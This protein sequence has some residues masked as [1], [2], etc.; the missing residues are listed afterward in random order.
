MPLQHQ[1]QLF[2]VLKNQIQETFQKRHPEIDASIKNWKGKEIK[3]FQKDLSDKVGG[4]ISEK[5]FYT[6]IKV[7]Q[8]HKLPR[9][10][11]L[12]MLA[13]YIGCVSWEDFEAQN[14]N[15]LTPVAATAN[16]KPFRFFKKKY[17]WVVGVGLVLTSVLM[18]SLVGVMPRENC[19][20]QFCFIDADTKE[21]LAG[22]D[23]EILLLEENESPY[24]L[25]CDSM[26]CFQVDCE[27]KSVVK[28][29]IKAPYYQI[30]T[31]SRSLNI[32]DKQEIISIEVDDYALMLHYF[33][34]TKI[35]DWQRRRQQLQEIIAANAQIIQVYS[36]VQIGVEIYNKE[37]FINKMTM[38]LK[39]LKNIEILETKRSQ[40]EITYIR[41]MQK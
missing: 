29:V 6:H 34:T 25:M 24:R 5:W 10:D 41:F 7:V 15:Y 21:P 16:K 17:H 18:I 13:Q 32:V 31:F 22:R 23:I 12:N 14:G 26:A 40:N 11:I 33:S 4:Y 28:F 3:A 20:Y 30:D 35:E 36:N 19:E 8:N 39:S 9:L 2:Q 27:R 38:P 1:I 37:E